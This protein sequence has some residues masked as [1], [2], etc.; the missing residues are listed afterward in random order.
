MDIEII[1]VKGLGLGRLS[2]LGEHDAFHLPF[3]SGIGEAI[4]RVGPSILG[5]FLFPTEALH[6]ISLASS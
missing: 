5:G 3:C 2:E 1:Q 4:D 6:C